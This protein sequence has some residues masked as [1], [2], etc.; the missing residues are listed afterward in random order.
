MSEGLIAIVSDT[1]SRPQNDVGDHLGFYVLN[2]PDLHGDDPGHGEGSRQMA[3]Y[4]VLCHGVDQ[5]H[6]ALACWV[7]GS[8]NSAISFGDTAILK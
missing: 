5:T 7:V 2:T 8:R 4:A 1:S 6:G 3:A